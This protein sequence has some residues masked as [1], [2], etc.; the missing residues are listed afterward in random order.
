MPRPL[1]RRRLL[2]GLVLGA[3][4]GGLAAPRAARA[5]AGV[6]LTTLRLTREEGELRLEFA[7]RLSLSRAVEDALQR[8]VP[9]Y[10]VAEATLYR[11]RWYWRDVR[12]ARVRRTWRIAYQPL[13]GSWRVSLGALSQTA[14]SLSEALSLATASGQ[15]R[16]ADLAQI[17]PTNRHYV[18]FV[19]RL[20]TAQLPSPMQFDL[21]GQDDWALRAERTLPLE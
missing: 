15:W 9:V 11:R 16:I 20:D 3:A 14:G 18:E 21:P 4:V 5:D 8:G 10:F 17:D 13:T 7:A 12:E 19:Y 1:H 6:E 2:Q